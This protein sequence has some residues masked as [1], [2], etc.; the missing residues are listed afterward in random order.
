MGLAHRTFPFQD[1]TAVHYLSQLERSTSLLTLLLVTALL[2]AWGCQSSG[3]RPASE[4]LSDAQQALAEGDDATA[5]SLAEDVRDDET[6]QIQAEQILAE[7]R[8]ERAQDFRDAGD[9]KQA[10]HLFLEA[11][12]LETRR[13]LRGQ[14]LKDALQSG[15]EA[16]IATEDLLELGQKALQDRPQDPDIHRVMA[17]SAEETH[18]TARALRH[19]LWLFSADSTDLQSGLRLGILYRAEQRPRDAAAVFSRLGEHH[20]EDT[21]LTLQQAQTLAELDDFEEARQL[22]DI[23]LER[24]PDHPGL[25][26]QIAQFEA[27]RGNNEASQR[28]TEKAVE[29]S[30][31]VDP[32]EM[33]PLR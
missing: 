25:L 24:H 8:R 12:S 6:H 23:L 14:D 15:V 11:A 31:T 33:R 28:Y 21:Q 20:P 5:R 30:E 27:R 22:F 3:D 26:R 17:R 9:A 19:Y 7:L 13:A 10:Y 18:D 4:S 16:R 2:A 1:S 29:A 32:R